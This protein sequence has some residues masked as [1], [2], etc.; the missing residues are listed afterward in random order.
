[1][2]WAACRATIEATLLVTRAKDVGRGKG[3]WWQ[4][5]YLRHYHM[6]RCQIFRKHSPHSV[7]G[8]ELRAAEQQR[9]IRAVAGTKGRQ[10]LWKQ[11]TNMT[12]CQNNARILTPACKHVPLSGDQWLSDLCLLSQGVSFPGWNC[13]CVSACTRVRWERINTY[14]A[15]AFRK[16]VIKLPCQSFMYEA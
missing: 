12:V 11:L 16:G 5:P 3:L 14:S 4:Y 1:M 10:Q 2:S 7:C 6:W 8:E 15:L 9:D 13:A